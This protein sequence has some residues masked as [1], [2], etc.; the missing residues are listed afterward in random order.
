MSIS[1]KFDPIRRG[2]GKRGDPRDRGFHRRPEGEALQEV[3]AENGLNRIAL[4]LTSADMSA[5]C[6]LYEF[7]P[8]Y[9][10]EI[11]AY[12]ES[13]GC[14]FAEAQYNTP[15]PT[16]VSQ[17]VE[18]SQFHIKFEGTSFRVTSGL[19]KQMWNEAE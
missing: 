6:A 4:E 11:L 16:V 13:N 2:D 18:E 7:H 8:S 14:T 5:I 17:Y 15:I 19:R 3:F 12:A 10:L 1:W 9:I